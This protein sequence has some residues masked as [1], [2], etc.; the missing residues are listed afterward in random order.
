[1]ADHGN[2]GHEWLPG[3]GRRASFLGQQAGQGILVTGKHQP[4]MRLQ[5]SAV[6]DELAEVRRLLRDTCSSRA[7]T[8][9]AQLRT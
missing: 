1:M 9:S 7:F 8:S 3:S 4:L 2:G 5:G 6:G